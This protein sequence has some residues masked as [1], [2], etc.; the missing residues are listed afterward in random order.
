MQHIQE[1]AAVFPYLYYQR[2]FVKG[3]LVVEV[4]SVFA[5]TSDVTKGYVYIRRRTKG[6]RI[7][8]LNNGFI[9]SVSHGQPIG[10]RESP[11]RDLAN[12]I[13]AE[14][15]AY[16]RDEPLTWVFTKGD[17]PR[18]VND[19]TYTEFLAC[20]PV[21]DRRDPLIGNFNLVSTYFNNFIDWYRLITGDISITPPGHW[22]SHIPMHSECVVDIRS[23]GSQPIDEVILDID[24]SGFQ[25][26]MFHVDLERNEAGSANAASGGFSNEQRIA[27]FLA[28]G[29]TVPLVHKRFAEIL[30]LAQET[31]DWALVALSMFPVFEQFFD[32]YIEEV[33]AQSATFAAFAKNERRN[34][35]IVYIGER[36]TWIP[37][38]LVHLGFD[39]AAAEPYFVELKQANEERVQVVHFNKQPAFQDATNLARILTNAV[40]LFEAALGRETA[41]RVPLIRKPPA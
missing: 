7:R 34:R 1:T 39:A 36:L 16:G 26:G 24:P 23:R 5:V 33:S 13:S 25:P 10:V 14:A 32:K 38:T 40:F 8:D 4:P 21:R 29:K 17:L 30:H 6:L 20:A 9:R 41:Y 3:Y 15:R 31:R 18:I 27:N 22:N 11:V 2:L 12:S 28:T 35:K 37:H 19:E